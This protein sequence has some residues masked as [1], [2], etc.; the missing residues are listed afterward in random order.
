MGMNSF[1]SYTFFLLPHSL[2]YMVEGP[3]FFPC[4]VRASVQFPAFFSLII[5]TMK[6]KHFSAPRSAR[7]L[8]FY[9]SSGSRLR[10]VEV[11]FWCRRSLRES[12]RRFLTS[13]F[14]RV[15][16]RSKC[17][18]LLLP[19]KRPTRVDICPTSPSFSLGRMSG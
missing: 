1:F 11:F 5:F 2:H 4:C 12:G 15:L 6:F 13:F 18:P 3:Q 14:L 10:R 9:S 19:W 8:E 17:R 16:M 7:L